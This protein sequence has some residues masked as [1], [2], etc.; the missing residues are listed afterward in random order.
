[1][2]GQQGLRRF[3]EFAR[4]YAKDLEN[5][6]SNDSGEERRRLLKQKA[7]DVRMLIAPR[8][9]GGYNG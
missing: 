2:R 7:E 3:E 9:L 6:A 4:A 8:V 5:R 1:M